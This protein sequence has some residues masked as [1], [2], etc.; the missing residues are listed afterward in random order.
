[1]HDLIFVHGTGVRA[2]SYNASFKLIKERWESDLS[3]ARRVHACYWGEL[4]S[5]MHAGGLC[6]PGDQP[7]DGTDDKEGPGRWA[8]LYEDPFA[9]LRT[10]SHVGG[11]E[12]GAAATGRELDRRFARLDLRAWFGQQNL[13]ALSEVGEQ[14]RAALR[15]HRTY[16]N[17]LQR[18]GASMSEFAGP[19][20]R[21]FFALVT[22]RCQA[23]FDEADAEAPAGPDEV[24]SEVA[25]QMLQYA[26]LQQP[27]VR[28]D[29]VKQMTEALVPGELAIT[30][31]EGF[32]LLMLALGLQLS[33]GAMSRSLD[34]KRR[35]LTDALFPIPGDI[36][37]YQARGSRVRDYIADRVRE[38]GKPVT[39]F[40]HS[41]GSVAAVELL[42]TTPLDN[43]AL[44]VT[45]GCPAPLFY[46]LD[47]LVTF[48]Y[49]KDRRLPAGF[50]PWLNLYDQRDVIAHLAAPIFGRPPATVRVKD[51]RVDNGQPAI[52]AHTS[53]W[54]NRQI[55]EA[56]DEF[57][58]GL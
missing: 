38:V 45:A 2:T 47:A 46:E 52:Y 43:V 16:R 25:E 14:V 11:D 23:L 27:D 6:I 39:L 20:V 10:M 3:P 28:D 32:D 56:I 31:S 42:A 44:L 36:L 21:A 30:A 1:M 18:V 57:C 48:P 54:T 26:A 49:G 37:H 9:E 34:R 53:Y 35:P 12:P 5:R 13:P 4:G 24:S 50:P 8:I 29:L 55:W 58:Q 15:Q 33:K 22:T 7:E 17:S 51:V 19:V 41:L 40:A